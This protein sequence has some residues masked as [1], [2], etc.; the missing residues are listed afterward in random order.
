MSRVH[1]F[2]SSCFVFKQ[3]R[4]PYLFSPL[5]RKPTCPRGE[6]R[7]PVFNGANKLTNPALSYKLFGHTHTHSHTTQT[8]STKQTY[9]HTRTHANTKNE[10]FRWW[11]RREAG[12]SPPEWQNALSERALVVVTSIGTFEQTKAGLVVSSINW[13]TVDSSLFVPH[14]A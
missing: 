8:H 10:C 6:K 4:A 14:F 12:N 3:D 11:E 5:V 13:V 1:P 7:R 2:H 9:T